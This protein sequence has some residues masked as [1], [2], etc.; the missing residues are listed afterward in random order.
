MSKSSAI[1]CVYGTDD[2]TMCD[3]DCF[4]N[5][6]TGEM[7]REEGKKNSAASETYRSHTCVAFSGN[8]CE[9]RCGG[10]ESCYGFTYTCAT[11]SKCIVTLVFMFGT[12][13][14][15]W[16]SQVG[17][18][19]SVTLYVRPSHLSRRALSSAPFLEDPTAGPPRSRT[20]LPAHPLAASLTSAI[21]RHA[22]G[23][24]SPCR[25]CR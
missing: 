10:K 12:L 11:G 7:C 22:G 16:S 20:P 1:S 23:L 13:Q 21:A 5:D 18:P 8:T 6:G 25:R 15:E 24:P 14:N 17:T 19:T 9:L 4:C 2:V 3:G